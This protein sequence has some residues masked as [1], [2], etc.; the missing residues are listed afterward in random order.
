AHILVIDHFAP[1]VSALRF[2][3]TQFLVTSAESTILA[4]LFDARP[5][6]GM[7]QAVIPLLYTGFISVGIAYTCQ[8]L[9]QRYAI[10]EHAAL[11][12][13]TE[14]LWGAVGGAI[15]LREDLGWRGYLGAALIIAGIVISQLESENPRREPPPNSTEYRQP[16]EAAGNL[17]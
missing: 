1:K 7:D 15:I 17:P 13:A 14:S 9:G 16:A 12:L 2:S 10:P 11:I 4:F 3:V 6:T 8:I 5:F